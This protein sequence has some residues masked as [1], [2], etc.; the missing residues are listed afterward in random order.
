MKRNSA[1]IGSCGSR[2]T[3]G[4][5]TPA[6]RKE[7]KELRQLIVT[8]LRRQGFRV[9]DDHILPPKRLDK[10]NM[11]KLHRLA[12]VHRVQRAEEQLARREPE[13]LAK[14]ASGTEVAPEKISPRLVEVQR[15]TTDELLFRYCSRDFSITP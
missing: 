2:Q 4:L 12:V 10:E 11:R 7:I 8:S 3:K 15:G 14:I 6:S 1:S 13:L 9:R 5:P